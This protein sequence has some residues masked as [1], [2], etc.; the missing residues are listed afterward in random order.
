VITTLQ[1]NIQEEDA[2]EGEK[3][4]AHEQAVYTEKRADDDDP[5]D[6]G[7]R[8]KAEQQGKQEHQ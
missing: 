8:Q 5:D 3:N 4:Q 2:G 1:E 7:E 6:A